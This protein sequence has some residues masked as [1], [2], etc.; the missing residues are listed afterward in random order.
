MHLCISFLPNLPPYV[1]LIS[2][3]T[4]Q[5]H[6]YIPQHTFHHLKFHRYATKFLSMSFSALSHNI[7]NFKEKII[8]FSTQLEANLPSLL[9]FQ[10]QFLIMQSW[11]SKH[12][13]DS[14]TVDIIDHQSHNEIL[15]KLHLY[16]LHSQSTTLNISYQQTLLTNFIH[17]KTF[18]KPH[19]LKLPIKIF[20]ALAHKID[21][22][23]F[24]DTTLH[25]LAVAENFKTTPNR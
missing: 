14:D 5:P 3:T 22:R 4:I 11:D 18:A 15:I 12:N 24:V 9:S 8:Q 2:H 17:A 7:Y 21:A 13:R 23:L 19:L 6:L 1:T 25:I 20:F 16:V 10:S